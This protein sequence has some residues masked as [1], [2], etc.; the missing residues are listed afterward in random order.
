MA[1]ANTSKISRCG[2]CVKTSCS[3]M[4][5]NVVEGYFHYVRKQKREI[6]RNEL[7]KGRG[8]LLY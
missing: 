2:V 4:D 1:R 7:I 8:F 6:H 3:S 5:K